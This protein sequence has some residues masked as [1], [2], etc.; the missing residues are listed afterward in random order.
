MNLRAAYKPGH[1]TFYGEV[2]NILNGNGNDIV[3]FY[4]TNVAGLDPPGVEIDGR[5]S[6]AEEPRTLRFGVKYQ[7]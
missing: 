4:P 3:Y 6:R 1:Y 2:L 7:F 5:V